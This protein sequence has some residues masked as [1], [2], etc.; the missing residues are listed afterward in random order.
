VS[1]ARMHGQASERR[2][3]R[4]CGTVLTSYNREPLCFRCQNEEPSGQRKDPSRG[5]T[6][7]S[8]PE[9]IVAPPGAAPG[10]G[11][12]RDTPPNLC[13]E[14]VVDLAN[15]LLRD[16]QRWG[17]IGVEY[18]FFHQFFNEPLQLELKQLRR[19]LY[20]Q[21]DP[22][23]P[24]TLSEAE[25][26]FGSCGEPT[27]GEVRDQAD[28]KMAEV[29]ALEAD[30]KKSVDQLDGLS[31]SLDRQELAARADPLSAVGEWIETLRKLRPYVKKASSRLA[32]FEITK[33]RFLS[34]LEEL[35]AKGLLDGGSR[36]TLRTPLKI[37]ASPI[38]DGQGSDKAQVFWQVARRLDE[39]ERALPTHLGSLYMALVCGTPPVPAN[40]GFQWTIALG[41][42]M[43][44]RIYSAKARD[45]S[46]LYRAIIEDYWG[47]RPRK[48][49]ATAAPDVE[50]EWVEEGP[51][52]YLKITLFPRPECIPTPS[53]VQ[54]ILRKEAAG[55]PFYDRRT[56]VFDVRKRIRT[57]ATA[58]LKLKCGMG[59]RDALWFWDAHCIHDRL[60]YLVEWDG[61]RGSCTASQEVQFEQEI[62]HVLQRLATMGWQPL[63]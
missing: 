51:L 27:L 57:W 52:P 17:L 16:P 45:I 53:Y 23:M 9:G 44:F 6:R 28:R 58:S 11:S 39:L 25:E 50:T 36:F 48:H 31:G 18:V 59:N 60:R 61:A 54:R 12:G 14:K 35:R 40:V 20:G 5:V 29:K 32:L 13:G 55:K 30:W 63:P 33:D 3:C 42:P 15:Q 34:L 49:R 2:T 22:P 43:V 24:M 38:A 4:R 1:K 62:H 56:K 26:I 41:Q 8:R 10:G 37:L 47:L 19:Q 7:N 21:E 46:G